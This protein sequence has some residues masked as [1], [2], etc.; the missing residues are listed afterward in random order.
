MAASVE[1]LGVGWAEEVARL[2]EEAVE[3]RMKKAGINH[4]LCHLSCVCSEA[5]SETALVAVLHKSSLFSQAVHDK[6]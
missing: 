5:F 6:C 1:D 2:S 3:M 4:N